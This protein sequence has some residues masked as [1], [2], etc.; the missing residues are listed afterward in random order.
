MRMP[1]DLGTCYIELAKLYQQAAEKEKQINDLLL[2][3]AIAKMAA[4]H[5]K[6]TKRLR[7]KGGR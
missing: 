3:R 2:E 4:S 1:T 6:R 7:L 5:P